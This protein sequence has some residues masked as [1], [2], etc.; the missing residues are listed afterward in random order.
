MTKPS[1]RLRITPWPLAL[2][3]AALMAPARADVITEGPKE[4][5]GVGID[6]KL[7]EQ[8]PLDLKFRDHS[9]QPITLENVFSGDRPVLLSLN[10]SDCPMLCQRQLNG[11]V[12][13]LQEIKWNAGDEFDVVSVSINPL[14]RPERARLTHKRYTQ[15]YGRPGTSDGWRFMVGDRQNIEA[16]TDAVGFRYNYIEDTGEY[17]HTAAVMVMT[18]DGVVSRYLYGVMYDPGTVRLSMVEAGDGKVGSAMDQIF[19]ICFI[20]DHTKGRYGPQA[21]RIM[22]FGAGATVLVLSLSLAPYWLRRR[23][24]VVQSPTTPDSTEKETV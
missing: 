5:I 4:M 16:L 19:L 20:Y 7:G 11:L 17:A 3:C 21:F 2:L 13:A 14:E 1:F 12:T 18:P 9:G 8:V 22:Q 24:L 10:Y 6:E 23:R 15:D